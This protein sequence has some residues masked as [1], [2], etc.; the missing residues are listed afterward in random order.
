MSR[1]TCKSCNWLMKMHDPFR[2]GYLCGNRDCKRFK[3]NNED[4]NNLEK[5]KQALQKNAKRKMKWIIISIAGDSLAKVDEISS[6]Q[7]IKDSIIDG[8]GLKAFP[9]DA[10]RVD[11]H[12]EDPMHNRTTGGPQRVDANG[13]T[14]APNQPMAPPKPSAGKGLNAQGLTYK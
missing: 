14:L 11:F 5:A 10:V 8:F 13:R 12:Y 9:I 4:M 7:A 2:I 6:P 3:M 1:V